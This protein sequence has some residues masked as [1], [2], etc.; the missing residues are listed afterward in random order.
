MS[1]R[2]LCLAGLLVAGVVT[3]EAPLY[4]EDPEQH[5]R[6]QGLLE[7]LRCLVCQNQSLTDSPAPLAQDMRREVHRMIEAGYGD[8]QVVEFLASRYGDF[9]HYR[10]PL[11]AATLLLWFGPLLLLGAA[12]WAVVYVVRRHAGAAIDTDAVDDG[13]RPC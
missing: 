8:Q 11:R 9:V 6:Y 13:N 2:W 5:E 3:A 7:E 4:F 10:P 1:V 12:A